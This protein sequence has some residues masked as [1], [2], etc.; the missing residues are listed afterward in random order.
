MLIQFILILI[1]LVIIW[2]LALRLK[3]K[4]ISTKQFGGWLLIWLVALVAVIWPDLTVWIANLVGVGRGSDLVIYLS[5]IFIIYF[6][7]RLLLRI[8]K[9]DKN[10]TKLVREEAI[11][12]YE[13]ESK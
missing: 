10:L 5:V 8:E 1:I 9:I 4:E 6:L 7:F 2:R 13:R 12:D 11:K 3:A